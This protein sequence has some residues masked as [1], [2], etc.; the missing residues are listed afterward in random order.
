MNEGQC[1]CSNDGP[2]LLL[3]FN[4]L[5]RNKGTPVSASYPQ[6]QMGILIIVQHY[7]S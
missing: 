1:K 4:C 2:A 3:S 6:C 7:K 5:C